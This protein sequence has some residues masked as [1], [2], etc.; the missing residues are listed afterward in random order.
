MFTGKEGKLISL[1]QAVTLVT[2]YRTSYPSKIKGAF[3]GRDILEELLAQ[4]G[5]KGIRIYLGEQ[6]PV[7]SKDFTYVAVAADASEND[8]LGKIADMAV[9]CPYNC[10]NTGGLK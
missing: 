6:G 3:L 10:S 9:P 7:S 2:D 5:A 4:P 8:I 1:P